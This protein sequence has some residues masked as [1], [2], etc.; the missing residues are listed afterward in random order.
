MSNLNGSE[1][2]HFQNGNVLP[3]DKITAINSSQNNFDMVSKKIG[4]KKSRKTLK[5]TK[6]QPKKNKPSM[7]IKKS[8]KIKKMTMKKRIMKM[9]GW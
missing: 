7:K 3:L 5:K 2:Q 1:F 4:G 9:F 8:N 6:K